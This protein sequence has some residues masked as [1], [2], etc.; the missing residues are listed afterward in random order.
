MGWLNM[1]SL[2]GSFQPETISLSI[3]VNIDPR[4]ECAKFDS[5]ACWLVPVVYRGPA[6]RAVYIK[7]QTQR[8]RN[9]GL[10]SQSSMNSVPASGPSSWGARSRWFWRR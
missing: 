2:I 1:K 8:R 9:S 10:S 4:C 5:P 3:G 7:R 6:R